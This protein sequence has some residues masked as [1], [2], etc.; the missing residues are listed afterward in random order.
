MMNVK[1]G[2]ATETLLQ[3]A[4]KPLIEFDGMQFIR[5]RQKVAGQSS[6]AGPDFDHARRM[7]TAG[8]DSEFFEDRITDQKVLSKFARQ[9]LV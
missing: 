3:A 8:G 9:A 2:I 5:K 4:H 1:L 7:R 6:A